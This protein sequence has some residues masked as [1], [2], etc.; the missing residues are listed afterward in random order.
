MCLL[1]QPVKITG[2]TKH[3]SA[4]LLRSCQHP[5]Q[6]NVHATACLN[7]NFIVRPS[8]QFYQQLWW[9]LL[10]LLLVEALQSSVDL[11]LFIRSFS[12]KHFLWAGVGLSALCQTPNHRARVSLFV[13]VITFDMSGMGCSTNSYATAIGWD[14]QQVNKSHP[15]L[16]ACHTVGFHTALLP[17]KDPLPNWQV[18]CI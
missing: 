5:A 7:F 2:F 11:N 17:D 14:L 18:S 3:V 8:H 1:T 12:T 9:H 16:H 13:W 6:I 4:M 10:L 15:T